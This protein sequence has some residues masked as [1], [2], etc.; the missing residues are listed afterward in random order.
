MDFVLDM[1]S[2]SA[3]ELGLLVEADELVADDVPFTLL[4]MP[5]NSELKDGASAVLVPSSDVTI[6]EV[7]CALY[8]VMEMAL[9]VAVS[10]PLLDV[11][12]PSAAVLEVA[13]V[14]FDV[15]VAEDAVLAVEAEPVVVL[16]SVSSV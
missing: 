10:V 9:I 2:L 11:V 13:P 7:F 1:I 5:D 3:L 15:F 16:L 8:R 4:S 14:E 12:L 6:S